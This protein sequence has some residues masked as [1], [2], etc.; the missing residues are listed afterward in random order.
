MCVYVYIC[1]YVCVSVCVCHIEFLGTSYDIGADISD[2]VDI[3]NI[4]GQCS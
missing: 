1:I 2:M 3:E 4:D